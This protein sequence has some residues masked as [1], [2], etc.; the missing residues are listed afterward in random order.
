MKRG[1]EPYALDHLDAHDYTDRFRNKQ[2][3][4]LDDSALDKIIRRCWWTEYTSLK[5]LA[6]EAAALEGALNS[7]PATS[8][9]PSHIR[10]CR[11]Q[12]ERLV[13]QGLLQEKE[14]SE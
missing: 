8:P 11:D 4:D 7:P 6:D 3:P 9:D 13:E 5:D 1:H 14:I 10:S 2:F 12:C